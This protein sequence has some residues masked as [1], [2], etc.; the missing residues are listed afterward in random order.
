AD[1]IADALLLFLETLDPFHQQAQAII[2][3]FGHVRF[4]SLAGSGGLRPAR[5]ALRLRG[6]RC[7]DTLGL[8]GEGFVGEGCQAANLFLGGAKLIVEAVALI[9]GSIAHAGQLAVLRP[10]LTELIAIARSLAFE[11]LDLRGLPR[12]DRLGS[13]DTP[14]EHRKPLPQR[15]TIHV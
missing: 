5:I 6:L 12:V 15:P 7:T 4:L 14:I 11:L 10:K 3:Y 8:R 13:A 1:V 2:G 9:P